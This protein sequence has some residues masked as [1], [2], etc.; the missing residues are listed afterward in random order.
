MGLGCR[1]VKATVNEGGDLITAIW[2]DG[3]MVSFRGSRKGHSHFGCTLHRDSGA[4]FVDLQNNSRSLY[5]SMVDAV[6]RTLPR[7][8]LCVKPEE[9]MEIVRIIEACN[10]SRESGKTEMV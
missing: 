6:L 2:G 4:Q 8:E 7:G 5:T 10:R 3:R 9:T 1:E